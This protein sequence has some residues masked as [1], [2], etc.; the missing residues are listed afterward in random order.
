MANLGL[1]K[2]HKE[3]YKDILTKLVSES[4][5]IQSLSSFDNAGLQIKTVVQKLE[6][7]I[8]KYEDVYNKCCA[9]EK[10][11]CSE[12]KEVADLIFESQEKL[13]ELKALLEHTQSVNKDSQPSPPV[14]AGLENQLS[15]LVKELHAKN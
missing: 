1:L 9:E 12:A 3:K 10:D 15:A 11:L 4:I 6:T 7:Y 13:E 8:V 2:C 5:Q 14:F